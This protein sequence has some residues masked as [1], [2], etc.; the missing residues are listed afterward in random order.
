MRRFARLR[1]ARHA[2]L[3]YI[4]WR[5]R[6]RVP[7][8]R[9]ESARTRKV[10]DIIILRASIRISSLRLTSGDEGAALRD[11]NTS[12]EYHW[13][14]SSRTRGTAIYTYRIQNARSR[15]VCRWI[16]NQNYGCCVTALLLVCIAEPSTIIRDINTRYAPAS[17]ASSPTLLK[18]YQRI[19][20]F[21]CAF[22]L[23]QEYHFR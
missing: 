19:W 7:S 2:T 5:R 13:I 17:F 8:R 23:D 12:G 14:P 11:T 3:L 20:H 4:L 1:R 6:L 22:L 21:C 9:S 18:R 15:Y 10:I 16:L